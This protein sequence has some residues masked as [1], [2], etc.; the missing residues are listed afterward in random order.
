M[1]WWGLI[2]SGTHIPGYPSSY[3]WKVVWVVPSSG[4]TVDADVTINSNGY[5][6]WL[7]FGNDYPYDDHRFFS[8]GISEG[9]WHRFQFYV[10]GS[11]NTDGQERIW[12]TLADGETTLVQNED[13]Q[14]LNAGDTNKRQRFHLNGYV[15]DTADSTPTY[16]D[17]YIAYG[18]YAQARV[19]IGDAGTYAN[20]ASLTMC[21]PTSWSDTSIACTVRQGNLA[22]DST[23]YVYVTDAN[24]VQSDGYIVTMGST[25][26]E[27]PATIQR[28]TIGGQYPVIGGM[29]PVITENN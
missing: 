26:S 13:K 14:T 6:Q 18:E 23:A 27:T 5:D 10:K 15:R 20:C 25:S 29:V 1:S 19:E 11:T 2:P 16:D 9:V 24:G 21:T 7:I 3:N 12:V 17:I 8:P 28:A 22:A 4:S